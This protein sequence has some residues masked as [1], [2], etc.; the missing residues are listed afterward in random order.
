[1]RSGWRFLG[2]ISPRA[3]SRSCRNLSGSA[4]LL[5]RRRPRYIDTSNRAMTPAHGARRRRRGNALRVIA[6]NAT[7]QSPSTLACRRSVRPIDS[8]RF[9]PRRPTS[10]PMS[11]T[12]MK[13]VMSMRV[14]SQ[15]KGK[16]FVDRTPGHGEA[17]L[18]DRRC[19]RMLGAEVEV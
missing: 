7:T 12:A 10:S 15:L 2:R 17:V 13:Y 9:S 1:M 19:Q 16:Q 11:P 8:S 18:D 5:V 4:R 14:S 3:R 6:A